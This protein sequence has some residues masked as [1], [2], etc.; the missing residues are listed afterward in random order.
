M[1]IWRFSMNFEFI[2]GL[3][4]LDRV[5]EVCVNAE[6]L[7]LS[8]PDLSMVSARKGAEAVAKS[9]FFVSHY[10]EAENLTVADILADPTVK[11]YINNKAVIN[12]FHTVRKKG[13]MAV[14]TLETKSTDEAMD[15]LRNLHYI[16]GEIAKRLKLLNEYP[17]FSTNITLKENAKIIN[18]DIDEVAQEIYKDYIIGES[19]IEHMKKEFAVL[20]SPFRFGLG[21]VD[22][23]ECIE[24]K[25]KPI[26]KE[27]ITSVQEHF[28]YVAMQAL[29]AKSTINEVNDDYG[30]IFSPELTIS[31]ENGYTTN[32]LYEFIN[33]ILYDLPDAEGFKIVSIYNGPSLEWGINDDVRKNFRRVVE[34]MGLTE[35][36]TYREY[37]FIYNSGEGFCNKLEN[38]KWVDLE[39]HYTTDIIDQDFEKDWWCW[40]M[41]ICIDFDH[42]KYPEIIDKLRQTVRNHIPKSQLE[43]CE[44]RWND[45]EKEVLLSSVEWK[46]RTLRVVQ[47]FLDEIN[48]V[49]KPIKSECQCDTFD[50]IWYQTNAPFAVAR[51]CWTEE[52]LTIKGTSL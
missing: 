23:N 30:V 19:Y 10:V 26:H 41:D 7:A 21:E 35:K 13:N 46:P 27:T 14:H 20:A 45:D 16:M 37:D 5:Y 36:F 8:K 47:N 22:L 29:K 50:S 12:A 32:D 51:I 52:G 11:N 28:G 24:F 3:G 49:L 17:A 39:A 44:S 31:G 9:V 15:V 42:A 25:N 38:G 2:K 4:C 48:E 1:I 34:Q 40:N 6:D 18:I 33:G 43:Y